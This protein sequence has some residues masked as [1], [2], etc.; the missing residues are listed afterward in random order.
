MTSIIRRDELT[1]LR[2]NYL[3]KLHERYK[4]LINDL[5]MIAERAAVD[6]DGDI[7]LTEQQQRKILRKLY[8]DAK[9]LSTANNLLKAYLRQVFQRLEETVP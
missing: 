7:W 6:E 1:R 2:T 5:N 3:P 4:E 9:A 8:R